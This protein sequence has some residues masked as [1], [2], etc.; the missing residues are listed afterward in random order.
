MH[1]SITL[2]FF[3][4][5]Y[6]TSSYA[7]E[8]STCRPLDITFDESSSPSFDS[9]FVPISPADSYSLTS[10]GLELYLYKPNGHVTTSA[11]VND[12]MGNGATINSTFTLYTGKVTVQV[13]SPTVAGVVVAWIWIGDDSSDEIDVELICG[14]PTSWQTNLFVQDPRESGPEYGV[15]NSKEKV[16]SITE[17]HAYSIEMDP[18]KISWSLDGRVV[19]TLAKDQCTRNNFSHYPTHSMRLQLGIWDASSSAGTAKWAKGP[20]DWDRAPEKITAIFKS[21][22]VECP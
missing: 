6:I 12:K 8:H 21:V 3:W 20:I 17:L 13:A 22:T 1:I 16:N 4:L 2:A 14:E 15:F 11:G 7:S 5:L 10:N 18:E 19:R 9:H